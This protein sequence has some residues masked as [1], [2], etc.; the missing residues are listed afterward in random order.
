MKIVKNK[1]AEAVAITLEQDSYLTNR[2]QGMN[3][4]KVIQLLKRL[5]RSDSYGQPE[6]PEAN[7][8]PRD[9]KLND[10]G[11]A[12]LN[13]DDKMTI[14]DVNTVLNQIRNTGGL[15][16]EDMG[17]E[18]L[19]KV[20]DSV[21]KTISVLATRPGVS[22]TDKTKDKKNITL[23]GDRILKNLEVAFEDLFEP[24]SLVSMQ[25]VLKVIAETETKLLREQKALVIE[26][27]G[28]E[29]F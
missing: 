20:R 5:G 2:L 9:N 12:P 21:R 24:K 8:A 29:K 11:A 23:I 16:F 10:P 18:M 26:I 3:R 27:K 14:N 17:N 13:R 25:E 19:N 28:S 7:Q 4:D 15:S 1:L 22:P 6:E